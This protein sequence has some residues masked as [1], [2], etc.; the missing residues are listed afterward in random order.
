MIEEVE[1]SNAT[2]LKFTLDIDIIGYKGI[3]YLPNSSKFKISILKQK[4]DSPTRGHVGF[5]KTYFKIQ[6]YFLLSGMKTNF[7]K[8]VAECN[9][10]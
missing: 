4:H 7:Q 2:R 6:Q 10:C 8:Y 5:L 3:I 1:G 9:T